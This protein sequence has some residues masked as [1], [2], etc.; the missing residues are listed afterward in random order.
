MTLSDL[1]NSIKTLLSEQF[2]NIPV[3]VEDKGDIEMEANN[4]LAKQGIYMLIR[5][6]N[7][8]NQGNIG[9][10]QIG[11]TVSSMLVQISE[12]PPVNRHKQ[13]YIAC[14]TLAIDVAKYLTNKL[15]GYITLNDIVSDYADTLMVGTVSFETTFIID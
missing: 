6:P 9:N 11:L 3:I 8:I 14:Q 13:N 10:N 15:N 4:A 5:F 2:P 1:S 7:I 12:H